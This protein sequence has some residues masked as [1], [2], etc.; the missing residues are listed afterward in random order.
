MYL[1]R[2]IKIANRFLLVAVLLLCLLPTFTRAE[3]GHFA[4]ISDTHIGSSDSVYE[5][6]IR[7]IDA[8]NIKVIIHCGD[9]I[10]TP[11][12]SKQ[13]KMFFDITGSNKILHIA[14]G[15][16][17]I[18]GKKSLNVF[19]RYFPALYHSFSDG[20]TLFI[21]LN[22]ELPGEEGMITGKQLEW[23]K[24]ELQKTYRYKFVFV[25]QPLFPIVGLHGLD[26]YKQA[27]DELHQLF[28]K[29]GVPL[30][31]S[32]HDHLYNR[33]KVDGITYIIAAGSGGQTRFFSDTRYYFRYIIG[34]RTNGG[35]SFIVKDMDGNTGDE[36]TI[37][38]N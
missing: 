22:S 14:P 10:H 21:F 12:S 8:Q 24:N 34:K 15:N 16:H 20:D 4:I 27:R 11:G 37:N 3:L 23:L 17:D 38:Q 7:I 28:A 35:Y 18:K 25:H 31:V 19:L 29:Q 13:W 32:G 26:K 36:F 5:D 30:V 33:R 2:L 6:F 1:N 9:A